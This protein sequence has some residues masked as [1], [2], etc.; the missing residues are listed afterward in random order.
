MIYAHRQTDSNQIPNRCN[1]S[2]QRVQRLL[3]RILLQASVVDWPPLASPFDWPSS[4]AVAFRVAISL[5]A[6][7]PV[8]VVLAV[9]VLAEDALDLAFAS[10]RAAA[11]NALG[12]DAAAVDSKRNDPLAMIPDYYYQCPK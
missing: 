8:A 9:I 2:F 1:C 11:G 6:S 5:V 10:S 3:T 7:A 12:W 4:F